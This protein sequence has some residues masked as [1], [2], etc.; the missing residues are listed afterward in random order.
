M[1]TAFVKIHSFVNSLNDNEIIRATDQKL[2]ESELKKEKNI[3]FKNDKGATHIYVRSGF[4][5][6]LMQKITSGTESAIQKQNIAKNLIIS[7]LDSLPDHL[8]NDQFVQD[9]IKNITNTLQNKDLKDFTA[10]MIKKDLDVI[11]NAFQ[12]QQGI[13]NPLYV[14][15]P[16]NPLYRAKSKETDHQN[17]NASATLPASSPTVM[18]NGQPDGAEESV[19][20]TMSTVEIPDGDDALSEL[21]VDGD[22]EDGDP[23]GNGKPAEETNSSLAESAPKINTTPVPI[24]KAIEQGMDVE[25]ATTQ[26][27]PSPVTSAPTSTADTKSIATANLYLDSLQSEWNPA[28]DGYFQISKPFYITGGVPTTSMLAQAYIIPAVKELEFSEENRVPSKG[29]DGRVVKGNHILHKHLNTDTERP[30]RPYLKLPVKSPNS[31]L[32]GPKKIMGNNAFQAKLE[33]DFKKDLFDTYTDSIKKVQNEYKKLNNG[34]ELDSLVIVP[35]SRINNNPSQI[36]IDVLASAV[37]STQHRFP[38]LKIHISASAAG[39]KQRIQVS[40]ENALKANS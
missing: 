36:E 12:F 18:K 16:I 21:G 37:I 11:N 3:D 32:F 20:S 2:S 27:T 40:F 39:Y 10:G 17:S 22:E 33:N 14:E 30:T 29:N 9:S 6:K 35:I 5:S 19:D 15:K 8:K 24:R 26:S 13:E 1:T 38:N 7:T 31:T 28:E 34:K 25:E 23:V 4:I